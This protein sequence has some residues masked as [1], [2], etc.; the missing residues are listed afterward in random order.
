MLTGIQRQQ[1]ASSL[2]SAFP[3]LDLLDPMLASINQQRLRIHTGLG[4]GMPGVIAEVVRYAEDEY[5]TTNLIS[6]AVANG[7]ANPALRQ[8]LQ[9]NPTLEPDA[10]QPAPVDH[11]SSQFLVGRRLFLCRPKLRTTLKDLGQGTNSRVLVVTGPRGGGKT[12]SKDFIG[13]LLQVE[14]RFVTSPNVIRYLLLDQY[15]DTLAVLASRLGGAFR[16]QASQIPPRPPEDKEQD[17]RWMPE[18]L[19]WLQNAIQADPKIT[20]WL[21]LDGFQALPQSGLD[22]IDSLINY[23]DLGTTNLRLIL[24]NYPQ[25][26]IDALPLQYQ[27]DIPSATLDPK[28]VEDFIRRVY[29]LSGKEADDALVNQTATKVFDKVSEELA[30]DPLPSRHLALL[31]LW[32]GKTARALLA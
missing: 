19:V 18:I 31:N 15:V 7:G 11:F 5:W 16:L 25:A 6:A 3:T 10:P 1:L 28:D 23:A 26:R 9:D 2:F 12:Y 4:I 21:V 32:L 17:S 27:E 29:L 14:P 24:L 30:K 13:Y 20:W 8:F 22:L